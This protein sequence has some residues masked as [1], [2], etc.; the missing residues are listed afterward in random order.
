VEYDLHTFLCRFISKHGSGHTFSA[1]IGQ[2]TGGTRDA[3]LLLLQI[4]KNIQKIKTF[5]LN[6]KQIIQTY[7]IRWT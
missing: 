3:L 7:T 1:N 2:Q 5:F 6:P 4:E